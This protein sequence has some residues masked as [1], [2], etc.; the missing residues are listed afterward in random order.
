TQ[1]ELMLTPSSQITITTTVPTTECLKTLPARK[2]CL[3]G[4]VLLTSTE[5]VLSVL[6]VGS[7][8]DPQ[9]SALSSLA[10]TS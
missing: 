6:K 5:R 10:V 7:M 3:A 9:I 4:L 2:T 8:K 1:K